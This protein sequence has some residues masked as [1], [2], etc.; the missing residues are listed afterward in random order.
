MPRQKL[1][2]KTAIVPTRRVLVEDLPEVTAKVHEVM[3]P[4]LQKVDAAQ[5]AARRA[6]NN[7]RKD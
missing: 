6:M 1:P 3:M 2:Y 7:N 5:D 4:Y